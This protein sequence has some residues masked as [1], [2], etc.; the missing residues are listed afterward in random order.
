MAIQFILGTATKDHRQAVITKLKQTLAADPQAQIFYLVPNHVKFDAEVSLLQGLRETAGAVVASSHV[1]TFSFS[2]L[3][4]YF[5]KDQP[6]YAQPRL[7]RAS[8]TMLVARLLAENVDQLQLFKGEAHAPGFVAKLA[9]QLS[10][11]SL[12]RIDAEILQTATAALAVG[13][14]HRAKFN[15]LAVMLKAYEAAIGPFATEPSLLAALT[16]DLAARD[17]SHTYF[18][19]NHFNELAASEQNLV[20]TLM[21]HAQQVTMCLTLPA[22]T[23]ADR[24]PQAPDLF[25]PA[26]RLYHRL[27]LAALRLGVKE[28]GAITANRRQVQAGISATEAFFIADTAMQPL[29]APPAVGDQV[30]LAKAQDPYTELRHVAQQINQAVHAGARYRDFLVIARHLDPYQDLIEPVFAEYQLP[31]FTDRERPMQHHPLVALLDSLFALRQHHYQYADVMRFLRTELVVPA[32]MELAAFRDA[33]DVCDN[34]LLRT[35]MNGSWWL[36]EQDWQYFRRRIDD[37]HI[38]ADD[39]KTQQINVIR[40]FVQTTI[41]PL[42]AAWQQA[43]TGQQAASALYDWLLQAGVVTQ[44]DARRQAAIASGDLTASQTGEQAWETFVALLDDYVAILGDQDFDQAQFEALL[45][46]GFASATFTQIPSTLDQVVVSET[47]LTRLPNFSH[48]F[49]IGATSLVMPD[50]PADL[51]LLTA[52]DREKLQPQLPETA[53]LPINGPQSS[54]GD[55]FINYLAIMAAQDSVCM[56]YPVYGERENRPSPYYTG[57]KQAL[58]LPKQTWGPIT[59]TTPVSAAAGTARSL[60]SDFVVAARTAA[61]Q[62]IALG[63]AWQAVLAAIKARDHTGLA[64][65]LAGSIHYRN[66]VGQLDPELAQKLY[67]RHLA[68][69]VSRLETYYRNPY[70]YFLKY[71]LRLTPRAEFAL[72]PADSGSLY[73]ETLNRVFNRLQARH[74]ALPDLDKSALP[75]LVQAELTQLLQEPGWEILTTSQ[76]MQYVQ[77]RTKKMLVAVLAAIHDQ[78]RRGQFRTQRTEL[79]FDGSGQHLAPLELPLGVD[80]SVTVRGKIDRL[81]TVSVN[82]EDFFLI[83]DYK[84]SARQFKPEEAYYGVAMQMLTYIDAVQ[85]G[86]HAAGRQSHPAGAVYFHLH[87]PQI[88]YAAQQDVAA[89]RFKAYKLY[90]LL[91]LPD[92]ADEATMLAGLL[93]AQLTTQ[94]GASPIVQIGTKKDGSFAKTSTKAITPEALSLYLAHNRRKITQAAGA[95]LAGNIALA[96]IQFDQEAATITNSDYQAIM[97]FDP[98]TGFDHYHRV[99][100]LDQATIM[101]K[102]QEERHD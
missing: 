82:G 1:Q 96:P 37:D 58:K 57:L 6:I 86:L 80:Q 12:G 34:H 76:Q 7:D 15:D 45:T 13:D 69:S 102:L 53:W 27:H 98:A 52:E 87:Q 11:L 35:G 21:Q 4:W 100:P 9:D 91:V 8:N 81:D 93:D 66:A 41:P 16:S 36:K 64:T 14:R 39:E 26:K 78:Q 17:L 43:A 94:S 46:A 23:P 42:F 99:L 33:V 95:I 31:V 30:Q 56:S 20:E 29:P 32:G 85:N 61:D 75:G 48:V 101:Q 22:D 88:K 10:E 90:G 92:D 73:H 47:A 74:I 70:E 71:G 25:L 50:V 51:G 5:L 38:L 84:S 72:T 67:G 68:V 28:L 63:P 54:L 49:V 97:T 83:V 59:L 65:R 24:S 18:F 89:E 2:R 62:K 60:L 77:G 55:P 79:P 40:R 3:A 19:L 44:L